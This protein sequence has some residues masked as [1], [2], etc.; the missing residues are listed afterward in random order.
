MLVD[1]GQSFFGLF[2][3][4]A[5][6]GHLLGHNLGVCGSILMKFSVSLVLPVRTNVGF[7][8]LISS[9]FGHQGDTILGHNL[10][11]CGRIVMKLSA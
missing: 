1:L 7:N 5:T 6:T 11:I 8:F 10:A 3:F 4:L 2:N 9:F